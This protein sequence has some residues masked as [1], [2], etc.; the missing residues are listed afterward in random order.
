MFKP[1]QLFREEETEKSE[2]F[3]YLHISYFPC[4]FIANIWTSD[5]L[6]KRLFFCCFIR[7]NIL[8]TGY[9]MTEYLQVSMGRGT[10]MSVVTSQNGSNCI[11]NGWRSSI[12][13][14]SELVLH[15][16]GSQ[17]H[18]F[19]TG[20]KIGMSE[21]EIVKVLLKLSKNLLLLE[22]RM[23]RWGETTKTKLNDAYH[24]NTHAFY[25]APHYLWSYLF[26]D[27]PFKR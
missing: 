16:R 23:I 11:L 9:E 20:R 3:H 7:E 24:F 22:Y 5:F 17:A 12:W 8:S 2:S 6:R 15:S 13:I 10:K 14:I 19:W 25:Y 26:D 1:R 18:I 4:A 21:I 27:R